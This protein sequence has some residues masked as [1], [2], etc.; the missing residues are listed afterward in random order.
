MK[1]TPDGWP[2]ISSAVYYQHPSKM[3]DWLCKAYGFAVRLKIEGEDGN[4]IH[5]E[6]TFGDDG[7]IS[8][9]GSKRNDKSD[10]AFCASPAE[11]GGKNTQSMGV[12]VDDVE[13][14]F[15][16]ARDAGAKIISEPK[17]TDYGE[18]YWTDRT[19]ETED[20]EGHH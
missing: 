3:I 1:K 19:Y 4:I 17:T 13:A 20:P 10:R 18:D 16:R 14:H 2:R 15:A 12:I 11:L 8:V 7:L 6:L 9:A 5:S